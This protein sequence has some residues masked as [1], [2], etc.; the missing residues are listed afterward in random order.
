MENL[1]WSLEEIKAKHKWVS[2]ETNRDGTKW[3]CRIR[4]DCGPNSN[5]HEVIGWGITPTA[6]LKK[7]WDKANESPENVKM[8]NRMGSVQPY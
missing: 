7:A 2:F 1:D 3:C 8:L 6:A 5:Y 4:I